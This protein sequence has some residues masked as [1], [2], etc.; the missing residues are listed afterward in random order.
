MRVLVAT[1]TWLPDINGVVNTLGALARAAPS[2]GAT[3]AFL[4][5]DGLRS[6][7]M[8]TYPGLRFVVA[9][10]RTIARQIVDLRPSAI[11]IATE[12]PIGVLVRRYCRINS[13][14]FT[15]SFHTRFPEYVAARTPI[16]ES[17]T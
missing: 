4:A 3:I 14:A 10:P 9:R 15:T 11:H 13:L 7:P 12:G 5:P 6:L 1:D 16:P 17:W 8:P 2:F